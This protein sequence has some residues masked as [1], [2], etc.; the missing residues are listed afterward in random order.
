MISFPPNPH[1]ALRIPHRS[2]SGPLSHQNPGGPDLSFNSPN[3]STLCNLTPRKASGQREPIWPAAAVV[4][5]TAL[6]PRP[7][8]QFG[9]RRAGRAERRKA[10]ETPAVDGVS[11]PLHLVSREGRTPKGNGDFIMVSCNFS[12]LVLGA[13]RAERR[14]AMETAIAFL[15]SKKFLQE[16][17]GQNAER[18]W[19]PPAVPGPLE[20]G[21]QRS[22]EGRTPK[23]NGDAQ[24]FDLVQC[25]VS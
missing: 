25:L 17:G 3:P 8:K 14:K 16:P 12:L 24:W 5:W 11:Y 15:I 9:S 18:Q 1:S 6:R 4:T 10:M 23:G 7:A 2:R 20:P 22:R 13:G 21:C 19:R